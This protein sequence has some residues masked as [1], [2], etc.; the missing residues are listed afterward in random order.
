MRPGASVNLRVESTGVMKKFLLGVLVGLVF[1]ALCGVIFL[2]VI[3]KLAT[4]KQAPT[5]AGNSVLLLNLDGDL[6]EA[7]PIEVP[8]PFFEQQSPVTVRDFWSALRFAANDKRIKAVVIRPHGLTAG[9]AKLQELRDDLV[10]FR[11]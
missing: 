7:A 1:A 4:S 6:P 9:W 10:A 5:I 3:A 11:K 8:L 2:L